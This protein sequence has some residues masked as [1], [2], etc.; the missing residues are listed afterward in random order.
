MSLGCPS[1]PVE[2]SPSVV[3]D[4]HTRAAFSLYLSIVDLIS[5]FFP[6]C[7]S[8]PIISKK[9]KKKKEDCNS[10]THPPP[11]IHNWAQSCVK[12]NWQAAV[13]DW[14]IFVKLSLNSCVERGRVLNINPFRQPKKGNRVLIVLKIKT[15]WIDN[16]LANYQM[17]SIS[18]TWIW[19]LIWFW[20]GMEL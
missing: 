20:V 11:Q 10:H 6:C 9:K 1:S 18:S 3:G 8:F 7:L 2:L 17:V 16:L 19:D 13:L 5:G 4:M 12:K 14:N 15:T